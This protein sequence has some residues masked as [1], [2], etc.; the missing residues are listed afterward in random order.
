M[1]FDYH[2]AQNDSRSHISCHPLCNGYKA[3]EEEP[4]SIFRLPKV[5]AAGVSQ[6][7]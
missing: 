4:G 3:A 5:K 1:A 6:M 7:L 2:D